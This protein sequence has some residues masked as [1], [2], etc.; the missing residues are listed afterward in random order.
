MHR[1]LVCVGS[2]IDPRANVARLLQELLTLS[3]EINVSRVIKTEPVGFSSPHKFLNLSVCLRSDQDEGTLKE[4]FNAIETKLGRDRS[5]PDKKLKDRVADLDILFKIPKGQMAIDQTPLPEEPYA[6]PTVVE[7]L[8]YLKITCGADVPPL[9]E[10]VEVP[11]GDVSL[12]KWPVTLHKDQRTGEIRIRQAALITGGAARLGKAIA[13]ALAEYGFD[14]ALHYHSSED[15]AQGTAAEIRECGVKCGTFQLD[16]SQVHEI[17]TFLEKV[18]THFPY[19]SLLVNNA[20]G[21]AQATI[22]DTEPEVF[23]AQM[24]VNL[25]APFFLT[26]AFAKV[27]GQ[28]NIVNILD[29]KIAFNQYPYAAYLLSKEALAELTRMAAL[30]LAPAVRVNG[31]APGVVLPGSARSD[32]YI[33][34]RKEG[35]PLRMKGETGHITQT[36]LYIIQNPFVTGQIFM[37]DGGES[38]SSVGRHAAAYQERE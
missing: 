29:N 38:I 31:V 1:Y 18:V 32:A 13:L 28:G 16:L 12:G 8:D 24:A 27:R 5:A 23:D 30:E 20:S 22:L 26:Q 6:R 19:L 10:G 7:L 3:D 25:R 15:T 35:I 14:I 9:P 36:I 21:Y 2:N 4:T 33:E 17:P 37:V 34:W 11:V